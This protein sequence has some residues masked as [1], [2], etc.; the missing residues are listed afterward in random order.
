MASYTLDDIRDAAEA[1][2]GSTDI[3]LGAGGTLR[4]V[5]VLRLPQEKRDRLQELQARAGEEGESGDPGDGLVEILRLV[6]EDE[7]RLDLLLEEVG[8]DLGV[9][10]TLVDTYVGATQAGEA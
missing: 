6:A 8:D 7:K 4:L 3:D 5:N 2:Y 1:K 9:L 10:A